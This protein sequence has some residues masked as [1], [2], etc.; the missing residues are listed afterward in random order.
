MELLSIN[1]W[2]LQYQQWNK[3][4]D[5]LGQHLKEF[6][7]VNLFLL[8]YAVLFEVGMGQGRSDSFP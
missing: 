7:E 2:Y 4:V 5:D 1:I 3:P 6:N 8:P